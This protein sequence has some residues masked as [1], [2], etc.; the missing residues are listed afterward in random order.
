MKNFIR[1]IFSLT[2]VTALMLCSNIPTMPVRAET[3]ESAEEELTDGTFT[4]EMKNGSY[5]IT[6]CESTA[7]VTEV[8][9]IRNGYPITAIGGNA[10]AGCNFISELVLPSTIKTIESNAFAGCTSLKKITLPEK[11]TSIPFGTFMNCTMLESIDIPDTVTEIGNYAFYNCSSL[12]TVDFPESLEN[13]GNMVF[14]ECSTIDSID[15]EGC[16]NFTFEGNVLYNSQKTKI[17]RASTK[18]AGDYYIENTVNSVEPGAFSVCVNI[19]KLFIPSSVNSIGED[20]FG[21]CTS[22]TDIDF[23]EGLTSIAPIAFKYCKSLKNADLP[24]S[25]SEIGEGAF[26]NCESLSRLII[27][28]GVTSVGMGAFLSC[29]ELSQAVIPRTIQEIGDNAFG[30]SEDED[31]G[32]YVK[33]ENFS[34]S[35]YSGSAGLDYAKKS[36]ISYTVT[37]KSIKGFVFGVIAFGL[38]ITVGI[39]AFL[40]MS[41]GKKSASA[42]VRKADKIARQKEEDEKYRKIL[43][44]EK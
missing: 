40:L 20:A 35:V 22:L 25:L 11:I 42:D 24:T 29:P 19:D 23:S 1:K 27:P 8:P 5:K 2:S 33:N 10:F 12:K 15:T 37:D 7:I 6:R 17:Y 9:E 41:K 14:A 26:Y 43:N 30:F 28:E 16:K 21:Y 13:L 39:I 4:Y 3:P 44:D 31:S 32:E 18:I 38:I 34:L 36:G